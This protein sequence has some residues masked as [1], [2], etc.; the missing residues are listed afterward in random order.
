[1]ADLLARRACAHLPL[2]GGR[3]TPLGNP[4][5]AAEPVTEAMLQAYATWLEMERR[6]LNWER[7]GGQGATFK[8]LEGRF[9]STTRSGASKAEAGRHPRRG[10][11]WCSPVECGW[12]EVAFTGR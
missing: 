6:F 3:V 8:A 4:T 10:R 5:K 11:P 2:I 7:A 9:G 12:R 1:M